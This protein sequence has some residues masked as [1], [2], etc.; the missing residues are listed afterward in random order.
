MEKEEEEEKV[1]DRGEEYSDSAAQGQRRKKPQEKPDPGRPQ[2]PQ[3]PQPRGQRPR[4]RE[5]QPQRPP[6]RRKRPQDQVNIVS[7]DAT[8]GDDD[9]GDVPVLFADPFEDVR[10][11][12]SPNRLY[13]VPVGR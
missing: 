11:P 13:D 4:P 9:D 7:Y 10:E 6:P 8:L 1:R 3:R 2:R 12:Q 5:Q